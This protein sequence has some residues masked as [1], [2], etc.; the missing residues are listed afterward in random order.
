MKVTTLAYQLRFSRWT[1]ATACDISTLETHT[2]NDGNAPL[3]V[4]F[5][6]APLPHTSCAKGSKFSRYKSPRDYYKRAR[7]YVCAFLFF[8]SPRCVCLNGER[9]RSGTI[10]TGISAGYKEIRPYIIV[11]LRRQTDVI[12]IMGSREESAGIR[13]ASVAVAST[14]VLG[15]LFNSIRRK[16]HIYYTL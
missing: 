11:C 6:L 13:F 7:V 12:E 15:R 5:S 9:T 10:Y 4:T 14:A 3:N 8:P 1:V 2:N 16:A